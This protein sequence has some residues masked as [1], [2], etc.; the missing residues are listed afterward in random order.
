MHRKDKAQ[1]GHVHAA[2]HLPTPLHGICSYDTS[3][4]L[5][6]VGM[7]GT[8][9]CTASKESLE[10]GIFVHVELMYRSSSSRWNVAALCVPEPLAMSCA[11]NTALLLLYNMRACTC[12]RMELIARSSSS[13]WNVAALCICLSSL[14]QASVLRL[15]RAL[16]S[17]AAV[18]QSRSSWRAT[19]PSYPF[20]P[21]SYMLSRLQKSR[22]SMP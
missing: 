2:Q 21:C 3:R 5:S 11:Q 4:H 18:I 19:L 12:V 13:R 15:D 8:F 20:H 14:V 7:W 9:Y 17:P 1:V 16:I 22:Q 10:T 6:W